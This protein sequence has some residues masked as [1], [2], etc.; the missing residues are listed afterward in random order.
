MTLWPPNSTI[1][2]VAA[3]TAATLPSSDC[4][5]SIIINIGA[6]I[7]VHLTVDCYTNTQPDSDAAN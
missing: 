1:T 7:T 3:I 4:K 2:A 5:A 6:P